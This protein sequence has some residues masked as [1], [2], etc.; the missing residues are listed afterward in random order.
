MSDANYFQVSDGEVV[1]VADIE[2]R[3]QIQS[4]QDTKQDILTA[5]D[6]IAIAENTISSSH[7]AIPMADD[8]TSEV[9]IPAAGGSF[10]TVDSV[11]RDEFGHVRS[12]NIKTVNIPAGGGGSGINS[13]SYDENIL[14]LHLSTGVDLTVAL[15]NPVTNLTL[16]GAHVNIEYA[17]GS[18]G[19]LILSGDDEVLPDSPNFVTSGA[20]YNAIS[21]TASELN[22]RINEKQNSLNPGFN[23]YMSGDTI[24]A[25]D[26]VYTAGD[27]ITIDGDVISAVNTTYSAGDNIGITDYEISAVNTTYSA[28]SNITIDENNVINAANTTYSF[29][30]VPTEDSTNGVTSGGVYS[31]IQSAASSVYEYKGACN[32]ADLPTTSSHIGDVYNLLDAS[33]FGPAGTNVAWNGTEWQ[34]LGGAYSAGDNITISNSGVI[35]ALNTTYSAGNN[36]SISSDNQISATNTTYTAGDNITIESDV[37]SAL[38]TTYSAG[39]NVSIEGNVINAVDTV[40]VEGDNITFGE[41]NSINS[42]HPVIEVQGDSTDSA[43]PMFGGSFNAVSEVTRDEDGH[44]LGVTTSLVTLPEAVL[45]P[46]PNITIVDGVISSTN[47]TYS[48]GENVTIDANNAINASHIEV[49][50][51][52]DT[53][54][55]IIPA[56]GSTV[57]MIDSVERD[58][59]GHVVS[60]N[61]KTMKL[62][63]A[64]VPIPIEI[65]TI[66]D[67]TS[68]NPVTNAAITSGIYTRIPEPEVEGLPG[69]VLVTDGYGGRSW[70]TPGG[71]GGGD[72]NTTYKLTNEDG[73]I[74]LTDSNNKTNTIPMDTAP[75]EDSVEPITSGAVYDALAGLTHYTAG[76]NISISSA[77]VISAVNTTYSA[78][79]NITIAGGVISATGTMY[80]FDDTPTEGSSN[81]VT[82]DGIYQAIQEHAGAIYTAGDNIEISDEY[83]ISSSHP[84]IMTDI[85]TTD[86]V[87]PQS[88]GTFDVVDSVTR[89][90]YGHVEKINTTT[91][92]L[93]VSQGKL[94]TLSNESGV[95]TLTDSDSGT[96]TV[97]MDNAPTLNSTAPVTSGGIYNW[98]INKL[99]VLFGQVAKDTLERFE[100]IAGET[101]GDLRLKDNKPS[102]PFPTKLDFRLMSIPSSITSMYQFLYAA[103][104]RDPQANISYY[105]SVTKLIL[106]IDTSSITNMN[107]AFNGMT[108]AMSIDVTGMNTSNVTNMLSMFRNC[109]SLTSLDISSFDML[110]VSNMRYFLSGCTSLQELDISGCNMSGCQDADQAFSNL[111]SLVTVITDEDTWLPS[112]R[113]IDFSASSHLTLASAINI[114]NALPAVDSSGY[115]YECSFAS[116]VYTEVSSD[117]AGSVALSDAQNRGWTIQSV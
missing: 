40:Y 92:T 49:V 64:S 12:I 88:G 70:A 68:D 84:P 35:S 41:D 14:T 112:W 117:S 100:L 48:A 23:I 28:G 3:T 61:T 113:V 25:I 29:D 13:V 37:I 74:T 78:G 5:G 115:T 76:A 111:N 107:A 94:Y 45:T 85:D 46:G 86:A 99:A 104:V 16:D 75:V 39:D 17:D 44:V 55:T 32:R 67:E 8:T 38:N 52:G 106:G 114:L 105:A 19:L 36:I 31:A 9:T 26:T 33:E 80:T 30:S 20:V 2:A 103:S 66:L 72:L 60:V 53:T 71:G 34:V 89:D 21:S 82:S 63:D 116:A 62:P 65:D 11:T 24:N 58:E 81:P 108:S 22:S 57:S 59:L 51:E 83:E 18:T 101:Y 42:S 87:S 54:S 93:P 1:N 15:G 47:T 4:L 90:E 110:R 73:V 56:A 77:G 91:V 95:L 69:Q 97:V 98:M 96:S 109:S 79:S 7:P 27:N 50:V 102:D 43:N 10:Y 6:N